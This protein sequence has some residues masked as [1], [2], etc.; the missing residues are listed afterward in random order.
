MY[1][2]PR[3]DPKES[4]EGTLVRDACTMLGPMRVLAELSTKARPE[5]REHLSQASQSYHW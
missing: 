2:W 4:P 5:E 1:K 3:F